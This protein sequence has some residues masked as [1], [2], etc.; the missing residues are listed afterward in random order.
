M[1]VVFRTRQLER[2][3]DNADR[4]VMDWGRDVGRRYVRRINQIIAARNV[5]DLYS[6]PF[7]RMHPLQGSRTG[8][9]SIYLTGRWRLI[10]TRG[11]TSEIVM[12]E[13]VS[14]HYDD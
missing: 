7:L 2:N 6:L 5:Y 13:E 10:L 12:I 1:Q 4:A 8:E 3:Y 9:L 14:N 11:D